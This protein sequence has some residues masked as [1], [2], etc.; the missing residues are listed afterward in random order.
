M[1]HIESS[2]VSEGNLLR[3]AA[4][5]AARLV[6]RQIAMLGSNDVELQGA[7]T[8]KGMRGTI[9]FIVPEG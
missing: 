9:S 1:A 5:P 2:E 3:Q 4:E 8:R 7:T 6:S